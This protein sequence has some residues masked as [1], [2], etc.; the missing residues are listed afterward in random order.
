MKNTAVALLI[1]LICAV[2]G[3]AVAAY[4][5]KGSAQSAASIEDSVVRMIYVNDAMRNSG[6]SVERVLL[7][8]KANRATLYASFS[9][10][11]SETVILKAYDRTG[12]EIGRSRRALVGKTDEA[13]YFD[14]EFNANVPLKLAES[15][16]LVY[17]AA[18]PPAEPEDVAEPSIETAV[19][20]SE[21]APEAVPAVS[22]AAEQVTETPAENAAETAVL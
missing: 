18:V 5:F 14:F 17:A 22:E 9:N 11:F 6:L 3:F 8:K 12:A 16:K 15:F 13:A 7:A 4:M 19:P 20:P 1:A 2:G 21:P 10:P